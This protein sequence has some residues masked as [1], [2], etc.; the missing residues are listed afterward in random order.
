MNDFEKRIRVDLGKKK[1]EENSI[2]GYS[3][4]GKGMWLK[5]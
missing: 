1:K 2:L 5:S 3:K 4:I